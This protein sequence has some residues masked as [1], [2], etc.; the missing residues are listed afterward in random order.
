MEVSHLLHHAL[1]ALREASNNA[2]K[3]YHA[4]KAA[5]TIKACSI[6]AAVAGVGAGLLPG[7]GGAVA[8]TACVAAIWGMYV[9]INMDLGISIAENALKS[10][11]SA[12]L[13][14]LIASAGYAAALFAVG[15]ML[16]FVPFLQPAAAAI[17]AMLSYVA[18]FASGILYI[19]LLTDVMKAKGK[20]VFDESEA[21]DLAKKVIDKSNVKEIVKEASDS[22]KKD[23]KDGNIKK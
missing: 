21:K 4:E 19:N 9:K 14:N 8:A 20:F 5:T 11:A 2:I 15:F 3:E 6:A 7:A 16:G 12:L 1:E 17:D 22:F 18:V 13:T 23:K 10:L